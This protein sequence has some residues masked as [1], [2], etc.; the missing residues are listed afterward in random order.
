MIHKT[1]T[2]YKIHIAGIYGLES[3]STVCFDLSR[4]ERELQLISI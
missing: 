3:A 2:L 1:T 4:V